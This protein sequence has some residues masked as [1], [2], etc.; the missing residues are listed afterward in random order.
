MCCTSDL[1]CSGSGD[2]ALVDDHIIDTS[3]AIAYSIS[4]LCYRM[5]VGSFDYKC[6]RFWILDVFLKL[7]LPTLIRRSSLKSLT[8]KVYFSSPS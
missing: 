1:E 4:D 2:H 8:M 6:D 5:C 7:L 3:K